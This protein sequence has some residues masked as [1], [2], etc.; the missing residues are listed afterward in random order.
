MINTTINE[1]LSNAIQFANEDEKD[2]I[3][4]IK[5]GI[6]KGERRGLIYDFLSKDTLTRGLY[7]LVIENDC[8]MFQIK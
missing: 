1:K 2:N 4:R 8:L 6:K 3:L 5:D 7:S